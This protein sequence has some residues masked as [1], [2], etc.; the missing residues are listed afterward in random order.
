MARPLSLFYADDMERLK[1]L[2]SINAVE[3]R[4]HIITRQNLYEDVID[5]Y[6]EGEVVGEYP[7]TISFLGEIGV[8]D[9][10]VHRDM[11]SGFWS[12][13]Y[14]TL[15]EG[16]TLLTPMIHP[17]VE[18]SHLPIVGRIISHGYLVAGILPVRI[19]FPTLVA[20]ILG[21]AVA[22][23]RGILLDTFLE[24][25]SSVERKTF[26]HAL[27]CSSSGVFSP[28]LRGDLMSTLSR[29]G[30]R[31][32]PAPS[33]LLNVIE[34]AAKFEFVSK[35]AAG[36]AM[37]NS[38]IPLHHKPFWANHSIDSILHIYR[39]L[40]LTPKKVSS[41][42]QFP[43]VCSPQESRVCDYLKLMVENMKIEE[44]RLFMRFVTGSSVCT[45]NEITVEFNGLS[46]LARVPIAHTCSCTLEL[47]TSYVNLD[48]FQ[49]DFR[50]IFSETN[51]EFTWRMD[52]V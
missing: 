4:V 5:L 43:S 15:F 8:D 25:I 45:A 18:F 39:K 50:A 32:L 10:G 12:T 11:Y 7:I 9:G 6:R 26:K 3:G 38:G 36:I 37:M 21:P 34:Q 29:F 44:L 20:I 33:N 46:G 40:T 19:A 41:L 52:T 14:T 2:K 1:Y 49:Q 28:E 35:P 24:Y 13:A 22:V 30:C 51:E 16:S 31:I 23:S 17:Q 48:D 47:P 27:A 42:F